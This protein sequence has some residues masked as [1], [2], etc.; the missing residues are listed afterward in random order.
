M[1]HVYGNSSCGMFSCC[2]SITCAHAAAVAVCIAGLTQADVVAAA[3]SIALRP[4]SLRTLSAAAASGLPVSILSVNWSKRMMQAVLQ[5]A[6]AA[7]NGQPQQQQ[8]LEIHAN[9]LA[10]G[11]NGVST[12][13][14]QREIQ[15]GRD[16]GRVMEDLLQQHRSSSSSSSG[17]VV[18]VGDSSSDIL[19]LIKVRIFTIGCVDE[20]R[21][22]C[23]AH[24]AFTAMQGVTCQ[25]RYCCSSRTKVSAALLPAQQ[26]ASCYK[27]IILC[28]GPAMQLCSNMCNCCHL[29]SAAG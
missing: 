4:G 2:I 15:C 26:I 21:F 13:N 22:A 7:A 12:G 11:P 3:D 25:R 14:I 10:W 16:K 9:E 1:L 24:R 6:A 23:V 18:Y 17:A 20:P 19:P 28:R 8:Q 27:R 5:P 29:A